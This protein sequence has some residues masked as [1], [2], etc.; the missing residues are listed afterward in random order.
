MSN[1]QTKKN[2]ASA[3]N[4]RNKRATFDY[5]VLDTYTAGLVLTGTEVKSLRAGKAGL[6][7]TFCI[8]DKGELWLKNAYIAEYF[9]GTYNN[10]NSHRDRKL[11]LSRKELRNLAN[12]SKE[13]GLTIVPLRLFF[14]EK[15]LAKMEIA[16]CK[17]KKQYDKRDSI[18]EQESRRELDR[19][20]KDFGKY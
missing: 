17:G 15:G 14:N 3:V 7:D 5:E 19:A 2:S 9:Y 13:P 4:I 16:L 6:T 20:K 12:D 11:L 18:K 8:F 10:H 1:K